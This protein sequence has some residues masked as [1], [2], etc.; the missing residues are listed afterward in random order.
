MMGSQGIKGYRFEKRETSMK[1]KLFAIIRIIPIE[2]VEDFE[3]GV[4]LEDN[5]DNE[6]IQV[7]EH[8]LG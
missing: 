5:F 4:F 6:N 7:V 2:A 8:L 1:G 3:I